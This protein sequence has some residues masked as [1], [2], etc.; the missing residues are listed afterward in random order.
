MK[1]GRKSLVYLF[2]VDTTQNH[3]CAVIMF[4]P[5]HPL[6]HRVLSF[7]NCRPVYTGKTGKE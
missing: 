6:H 7:L 5:T 4:L 1:G 2:V 3:T